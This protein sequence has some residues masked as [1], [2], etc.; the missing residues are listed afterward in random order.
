VFAHG[1]EGKEPGAAPVP[2]RPGPTLTRALCLGGVGLPRLGYRPDWFLLDLLALRRNSQPLGRAAWTISTASR[3]AGMSA[4]HQRN[5]I[6]T[7]FRRADR[8]AV[9]DGV[10]EVDCIMP[11]P[12]P[13]IFLR[14]LGPLLD[15]PRPECRQCG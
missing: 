9:I 7:P 12:P 1:Y 13:P 15:T 4:S 2:R 14:L 6:R 10:G 11:T 8:M 5:C 3:W